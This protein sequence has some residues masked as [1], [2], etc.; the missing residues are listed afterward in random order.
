MRQVWVAVLVLVG[1]A[2]YAGQT[3]THSFTNDSRGAH[4]STLTYSSGVITVDMSA[5]PDGVQVF[6]A[7]LVHDRGGSGGSFPASQRSTQPLQVEDPDAPGVWLQT[8]P[9]RHYHLDCTAAV[10]NAVSSN[11][12]TLT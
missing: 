9:P 6:R 12:K 7:M 4:P 11:P 10:Q 3:S 1:S 5:L 8:V 2:V